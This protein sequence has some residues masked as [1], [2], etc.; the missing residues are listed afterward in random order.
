MLFSSC[1]Q[2]LYTHSAN[3]LLTGPNGTAK[4]LLSQQAAQQWDTLGWVLFGLALHSMLEDEHSE[5]NRH[6]P[7]QTALFLALWDD[8]LIVTLPAA[9]AATF[10]LDRTLAPGHQSGAP[11]GKFHDVV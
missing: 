11:A 6:V 4:L 3:F 8:I 5:R 10:K 9:A 7:H 1:S 2:A